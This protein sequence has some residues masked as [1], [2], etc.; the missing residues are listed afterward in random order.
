MG[1]IVDKRGRRYGRLTVLEITGKMQST[2]TVWKCQCDCGKI[3]EVASSN[4][5]SGGTKSCGCTKYEDLSKKYQMD[6]TGQKFGLLTA[7][8]S[9]GKPNNSKVT[10]WECVCECGN[11]TNAVLKNLRKGQ[12]RSCGCL[13]DFSAAHEKVLKEGTNLER[14]SG[15][16]RSNTGV[17]GVTRQKDGRYV[18]KIGFQ[19]VRYN[20]GK[21]EKLE[22]A[23]H[24]RK[25]AEE[26]YHKPILEKYK[27]GKSEV[28][29]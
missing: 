2:H 15:K 5:W 10:I 21:F 4:L 17:R 14:I 29:E 11:R 1:R 24:A 26:K 18:A 23:I 6:I 16:P 13:L 25:A 12:T 27:Y 20:L 8:K 22:D 19:G 3:F 28:E 7:V 9:L